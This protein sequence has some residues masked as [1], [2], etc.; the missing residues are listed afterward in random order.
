MSRQFNRQ[1][2]RIAAFDLDGTVLQGSLISDEVVRALGKLSDMGV[3]ITVST[4]RDISQIPRDVLSCFRYRVTANGASVTDS[5]GN[6]L[7]DHPMDSRTAIRALSIIRRCHGTSCVY[8][9][10]FVVATPLFL[11]RLLRRTNYLS[12]TH[13]KATREVRRNRIVLRMRGH[14]GKGGLKVYR[15][16]TFF[17]NQ[18]DALNAAQLLRETGIFNP[19]VLEDS[20]METTLSG[21]TKAHGLLELCSVL[22]CTSDSIIAFGDSANDLEM[23][24]TAG[25]SVGMGNSEQCVKMEADYITDPVT[26]DGVATAIDKLF[27]LY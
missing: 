15:I 24:R 22:G 19:I 17:N 25:F 27:G 1:N 18:A 12:K 14:V 21:I 7:E 5:E 23:F 26:E 6:I 9:N 10:G 3:A 2:I 4:A 11:I 13:R 8:L 16:Q 20:S